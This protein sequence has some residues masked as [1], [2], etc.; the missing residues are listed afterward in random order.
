M[1]SCHGIIHAYNASPNLRELTERRTSSSLPFCARYRL[2]DFPLSFM[3]NAGVRDVGVIMQRDYQSLLDHLGSGKDWDL[4]RR[5]G[6]LKQLPPFG[7]ADS[8]TGEYKGTMEALTAVASYIE[9]IPQ[10]TV[11]MSRGDIVAN[12]NLQKVVD[13]HNA[14]GAEITAVCT[15]AVP[16]QIHH[17]FLTG[18]E[19]FATHLLCRRRGAGPG[20]A[21]ME[22]YV[23]SKSRLLELMSYCSAYNKKHFHRDALLD[24]LEKGG[25]VYVYE[26]KG[27]TAHID[28][29][30]DYYK[31]SMDMF[32]YNN[33]M[34]L[35]APSHPIRTKERSDVSTYYGPHAYSKNSLVADGC[36]IEGEIENCILFRGVRI[37]RE[38]K[39]KNCVI[40]QD[41]IVGASSKLSYVI[42]DKNVVVSRDTVLSGNARL[43][44][45]VPKG[46]VV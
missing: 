3:V 1:R 24:Y 9:H 17:R 36:Y 6:G 27:Y 14:S 44:I 4:S 13:Q 22:I 21:S 18:P 42:C 34:E 15:Q 43:L 31:V 35:F 2:I 45:T 26:H 16:A 32:N 38:A 12:V 20:L 7:L 28:T 10:E 11:I 40:M 33:R 8:H 25:K 30:R 46:D 19:S 5:S 23:I 39:L 41:T 29:V 37:E